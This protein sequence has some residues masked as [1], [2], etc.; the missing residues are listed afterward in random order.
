[1]PFL[2]FDTND[3]LLK[4]QQ[5]DQ[6]Q[7]ISGQSSVIN[8]PTQP[9][10]ASKNG[11]KSSGSFVNLQKYLDAN[12][13]NAEQMGQTITSNLNNQ[14]MDAQSKVNVFAN[15]GPQAI[16]KETTDSINQ[17]LDNALNTDKNQYKSLKDT[18]GYTGPS[19][20]DQINGYTDAQKSTQKAQNDLNLSKTEEGRQNLLTNTYSRPNYSQGQKTFDNLLLQNNPS[21]KKMFED[22]SSRWANL[23]SLLDSAQ[24]NAQN[25]INSNKQTALANKEL[26]N[27]TEEDYVNNFINPIQQRADQFNQDSASRIGSL[28]ADLADDSLKS[29]TLSFLGIDPGQKLWDLNLNDYMNYDQTQADLNNVATNEE[30]TRWAAL[31]NLLDGNDQRITQDGKTINPASFDKEKFLADQKAAEDFFNQAASNTKFSQDFGFG[32]HDS[33]S[34]LERMVGDNGAWIGIGQGSV[35][36][37]DYL[38]NGDAAFQYG[39]GGGRVGEGNYWDSANAAK[40][41]MR[42]LINQWLEQQK[43]NRILNQEIRP[44]NFTPKPHLPVSG[45]LKK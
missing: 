45:G 6:N 11:P 43:Y 30:R 40:E 32:G 3:E 4:K 23:N 29:D 9:T 26:V 5:L 14:A 41:N 13:G 7:N 12:K 1:M 20:Y 2:P 10:Q 18:G 34:D 27:K 25:T 24:T 21:S 37:A 44:T 38:K 31:Q 36:V 16:Q 39:S 19:Y 8:N 42:N 22:T 15:N 28:K 33:V 17:R 35:S